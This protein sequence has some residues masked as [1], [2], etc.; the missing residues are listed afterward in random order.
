MIDTRRLSVFAAALLTTTILIACGGGTTASSAPSTEPG[1][2]EPAAS[3]PTQSAPPTETAVAS[4][5]LPSIGA[6]PSFDLEALAG[7]LPVDSYRTSVSLSGEVQYESVVVTEPEL[8][9]AITVYD[10]GNVSTRCIVIGQRAWMADGADGAF[11]EVPAALAGSMLVAF[12]PAMMLSGF[13]TV[14]WTEPSFQVGTEQKN[15]VQAHHL[16]IDSTTALG[17]AGAIPPGAALDIWVAEAGYLVAWEMSGFPDDANF[18]IQVTNV[19]DP[20]NQVV[21]PS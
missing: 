4:E 9:K 3:A 15:G 16:R 21:A 11:E 2:T 10:S 7:A 18:S 13:E 12:D 6:I 14:D 8:S 19:D 17:A 5:A 20:A 1:A